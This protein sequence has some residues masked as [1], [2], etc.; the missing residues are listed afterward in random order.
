[1]ALV[2]CP[3]CELN[4]MQSTDTYCS[5][6]RKE[7]MGEKEER[8]EVELCIECGENPA[9][10][11]GELC[12]ACLIEQ[13][14]ENS[15]GTQESVPVEEV[16]DL[17]AASAM[18]EI[19]IEMDEAI[20]SDEYNAINEDLSKDD[21]ETMDD[22]EQEDAGDEMEDILETGDVVDALLLKDEGEDDEDD[23]NA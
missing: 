18:D 8:I 9:I 21:E 2:K 16:L 7:V 20:P 5:I 13:R 19:E 22:E 4:Y 17:T 3:R 23:E 11:G 15:K 1:M 6:C 10:P 12:R 14:R